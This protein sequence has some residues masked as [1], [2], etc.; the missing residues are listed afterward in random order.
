MVPSGPM[1]CHFD[2]LSNPTRTLLGVARGTLLSSHR[3]TA[4]ASMDCRLL[5]PA[6]TIVDGAPSPCAYRVHLER[7]GLDPETG[8]EG[9]QCM[10]MLLQGGSD[11][12]GGLG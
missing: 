2:H 8:S 7:G 6:H 4:R 1:L 5:K 9:G 3:R 10:E 11:L 12:E